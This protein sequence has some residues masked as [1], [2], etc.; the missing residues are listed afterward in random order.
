MLKM[1]P[2]KYETI[3][4]KGTCLTLITNGRKSK[5]MIDGVP[6]FS[7]N[8]K[9]NEVRF[10]SPG[11]PEPES[12]VII[13]CLTALNEQQKSDIRQFYKR[14]IPLYAMVLSKY[15]IVTPVMNLQTYADT[16]ACGQSIGLYMCA[17]GAVLVDTKYGKVDIIPAKA[18]PIDQM[19]AIKPIDVNCEPRMHGWYSIFTAALVEYAIGLLSRTKNL[20]VVELGSWFGK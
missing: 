8:P 1:M 3:I 12:D 6:K 7:I 2:Y 15:M 19:R 10:V 5:P 13:I 17:M 20:T 9:L 14:R 11:D 16:S 18:C 4:P